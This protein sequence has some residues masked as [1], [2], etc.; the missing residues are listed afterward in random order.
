M[1]QL[2]DKND[3]FKQYL[4]YFSVSRSGIKFAKSQQCVAV[5][6]SK[7]DLET[8]VPFDEI[9]GHRGAIVR[10]DFRRRRPDE[11]REQC[12]SRV[13]T[14]RQVGSYQRPHLLLDA[15]HHQ[16]AAIR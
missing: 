7:N 11:N 1:S 13:G 16:V 15:V 3:N 9:P 8:F 10:S 2:S 12:R 6:T 5:P 14:G 4:M